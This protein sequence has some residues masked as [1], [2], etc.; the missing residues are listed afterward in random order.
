MR[1]I[2]INDLHFTVGPNGGVVTFHERPLIMSS[3]KRSELVT[4]EDNE[5][6]FKLG[7]LLQGPLIKDY[8][9]TIQSVLYYA[10]IYSE[11]PLVLSTWATTVSSNSLGAIPA[12]VQIIVNAEPPTSGPQNINKQIVSTLTGIRRLIDMGCTHIL[13]LRSDQRLYSKHF[14]EF[15]R[16]LD[17]QFPIFVG[18]KQK[19]RLIVPSLDS[20]KYRLCGLSDHMIFGS[21]S[22]LLLLFECP[23]DL[24][25]QLDIGW[26]KA[27]NWREYDKL[28]L[29][30]VYLFRHFVDAVSAAQPKTLKQ[31]WELVKD[32]FLIIDHSCLDIL[33]PKYSTSEYRWRNYFGEKSRLHSEFSFSDWLILFST[34]SEK[35]VV[36]EKILDEPF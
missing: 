34:L 27:T 9:F 22:D 5:N 31:S 35:W 28:N 30:E 16:A 32:R 3:A 36:E 10:N 6:H 11:L 26:E 24:R 20:F 2:N 23:F 7:L 8:N 21:A 13:K 14:V 1:S 12:N 18:G 33:W 29:C 17:K 15:L 19:S 25:E 4:M